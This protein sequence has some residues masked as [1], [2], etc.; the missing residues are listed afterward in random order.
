[1]PTFNRKFFKKNDG[2]HFSSV[3]RRKSKLN[4][5]KRITTLLFIIISLAAC[6]KHSEKPREIVLNETLKSGD[7]YILDL[8][9]YSREIESAAITQQAKV[10]TISEINTTSWAY[11]FSSSAKSAQQEK[12][13]ININKERKCNDDDDDDQEKDDDDTLTITILFS[14]KM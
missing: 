13:V 11:F 4:F 12:V 3:T 14:I 10:F 1:M 2:F 6:E 9:T 7:K 8:T 5:M